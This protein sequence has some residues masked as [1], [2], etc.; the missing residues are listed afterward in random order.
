MSDI[1]SP[2]QIK[3]IRMAAENGDASKQYEL[4]KIYEAGCGLPKNAAKA[5]QWIQM[6]VARGVA[7]EQNKQVGHADLMA[8]LRSQCLNLQESSREKSAEEL[9]RAA[10]EGDARAQQQLGQIYLDGSGVKKAPAVALK[11]FRMA[12]DQGDAEGQWKL[13][14]IYAKGLCVEKNGE[15][16]AKWWRMAAEQGLTMAQTRLIYFAQSGDAASQLNV[17]I[18]AENGFVEAQDF[19]GEMYAQGLGVA[20]DMVESVKWYRMAAEQGNLGAGSS[21]CRL[22]ELGV[23]DALAYWKQ[24]AEQGDAQA[25]FNLGLLYCKG[26]GVP[27]D[28]ATAMGWW[29]KAADQGDVE[30]RSY[31]WRKVEYGEWH[32]EQQKGRQPDANAR[33]RIWEMAYLGN[34]D[35]QSYMEQM[36]NRGDTEAQ[37][38]L[39]FMYEDGVGVTKDGAEAV[40]WFRMAARQGIRSAESALWRMAESVPD[41]RIYLE[42]KAERGDAEAEFKLGVIY[43]GGFGVEKHAEIAMEWFRKATERGHTNARRFLFKMAEK[44]D[45]DTLPILKQMAKQGNGDVAYDLA[46][47]FE[48]GRGVEKDE[49]AAREWYCLA[50]DLG[51]YGIFRKCQPDLP[52]PQQPKKDDPPAPQ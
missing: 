31:W 2:I 36:A 51:N 5:E 21:L 41:A 1:W 12:A 11:W 25:Q 13:G 6:A 27:K 49:E 19:L 23:A 29:C 38:T 48:E 10:T 24:K 30:A 4:G 47:M 44:H 35:A 52:Q 14:E 16:A 15:E 40:K 37:Y 8:E 32:Y 50:G 34:A 33:A 17:K 18:M 42:Q 7:R 22:A 26:C 45:A 3:L 20:K 9:E 39:G 28:D 46:Q 43:F